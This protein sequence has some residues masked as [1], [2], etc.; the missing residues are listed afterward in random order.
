MLYLLYVVLLLRI[1]GQEWK[2]RPLVRS[3]LDRELKSICWASLSQR[4]LEWK[5]QQLSKKS[6]SKWV[7]A[8]INAIGYGDA[9]DREEKVKID[10]H[11]PYL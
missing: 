1:V 4:S 11:F 9:Q 3:L 10:Q 6:S 5:P 8:G 7:D 2:E